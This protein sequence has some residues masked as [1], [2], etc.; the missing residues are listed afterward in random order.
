MDERELD[1]L[2]IAHCVNG[3]EEYGE[4]PPLIPSF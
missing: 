1:A 3:I 2:D 4:W